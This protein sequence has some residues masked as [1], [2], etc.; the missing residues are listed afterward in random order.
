M[1]VVELKSVKVGWRE[2]GISEPE[3]NPF[4]DQW[5]YKSADTIYK[6][7][8][9]NGAKFDKSPML[10]GMASEPSVEF[11]FDGDRFTFQLELFLAIATK[12]EN[13]KS[14]EKIKQILEVL[15]E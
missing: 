15:E 2:I 5:V 13:K 6:A 12:Y 3:Q 14:L 7:L 10:A 8:V 9:A 11:E 4:G 1:K